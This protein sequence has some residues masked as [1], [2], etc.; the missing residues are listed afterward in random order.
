MLWKIENI[1]ASSSSR[2]PYASKYIPFKTCIVHKTFKVF[3]LKC[4]NWISKACFV[5]VKINLD[6]IIII[7]NKIWQRW[8][9]YCLIGQFD[10][11]QRRFTS[12]AA[13]FMTYIYLTRP[14]HFN[15][16]QSSCI[17]NCVAHIY[18]PVKGK[19]SGIWE[20]RVIKLYLKLFSMISK[21]LRKRE[22]I[23][24]Q[25]LNL[26]VFCKILLLFIERIF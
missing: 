20:I 4:V 23:K 9:A 18:R 7:R 12:Y 14:G 16:P 24:I 15:W 26:L 3:M 2:K 13:L 19:V 11:K 22:D 25:K 6:I 10:K 17:E 8:V 1:E 5:K 21:L